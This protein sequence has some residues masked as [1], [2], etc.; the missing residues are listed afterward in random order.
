MFGTLRTL[1]DGANA[2]AEERLR[3]AYSVELIDQKIREAT[4]GLKQAKMT[5]AGFIQRERAEA[6]QVEALEG[7][8]ADLTT[9]A[10]AAL[11]EGRED[12]ATEAA[13]VI[14]TLE[15]ERL[16][17]TTTRQRLEAR[18]IRLR[19]T[20]ETVN[21]RIIDLR[22]GATAARATK[23]EYGMQ[24]RLNKTL[25]GADALSEAEEL[26]AGVLGADDPFEQAQ[27]LEEIDAGL[28]GKDVAEKMGREGFGA[29]VRTTGADVLE[30]LKS[31]K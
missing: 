21:R 15:N 19:A 3:D 27:I 14:A 2:R 6:R 29:P 10:Q 25:S 1:F 23:A 5:L 24:R 13:E 20:I 8:I 17:R 30:R 12:L 28:T 18:I 31:K 7:R 16:M 26:I 9:R 4:A 11:K 22:Q